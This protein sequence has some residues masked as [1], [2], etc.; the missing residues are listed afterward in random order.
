M[1]FR[2][3]YI[4]NQLL[5]SPHTIQAACQ[6]GCSNLCHVLTTDPECTETS[7][8]EQC[9]IF[10]D[11]SH[12]KY[13]QDYLNFVLPDAVLYNVT[14]AFSVKYRKNYQQTNK[15]NKKL[16]LSNNNSNI[17]ASEHV[18]RIQCHTN[19]QKSYLK[20]TIQYFHVRAT[21]YSSVIQ[22]WLKLVKN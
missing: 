4:T 20:P 1:D 15:N 16:H 13:I 22:P 8:H 6:D 9:P 7:F 2:S 5:R 11:P 10:Q 19:T 14:V 3:K 18:A 21:L 12:E 17:A